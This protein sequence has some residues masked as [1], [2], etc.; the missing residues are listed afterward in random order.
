MNRLSISQRC[1][2]TGPLRGYYHGKVLNRD[3]LLAF[4]ISFAAGM[5][6]IGHAEAAEYNGLTAKALPMVELGVPLNKTSPIRIL[7]GGVATS[8]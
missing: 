6:A 2:K 8:R 1:L 7:P 3:A 5:G 4:T